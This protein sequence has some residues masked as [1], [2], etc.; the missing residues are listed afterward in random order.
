M[1]ITLFPEGVLQFQL[2]DRQNTI[3]KKPAIGNE[4]EYALQSFAKA[5]A[6]A[7][8][9]IENLMA[10]TPEPTLE[11]KTILREAEQCDKGFSAT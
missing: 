1:S 5:S 6:V 8:L 10:P 11:P 4:H 3:A 7:L 2:S 9:E